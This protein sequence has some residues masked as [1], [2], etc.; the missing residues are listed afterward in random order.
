MRTQPQ[1]IRC[2]ACRILLATLD[3]T[4][5]VIRRGELQATIDGELRAALVCYRRNCRH[6]NVVRHSS[7]SRSVM[8]TA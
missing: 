6:L 7:T 4:G 2:T 3:E 1:E 8:A 5:L